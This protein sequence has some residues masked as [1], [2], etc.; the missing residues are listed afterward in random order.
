MSGSSISGSDA[1][2]TYARRV[3]EPPIHPLENPIVWL[4][5]QLVEL[6][7]VITLF[8]WLVPSGWSAGARVILIV[9]IVGLVTWGN[10][11]VRRRFIP[12]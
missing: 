2:P 8:K 7:I 11:V 3:S 6:V 10:Y 9:A 12:R 1:P 5:I 4:G